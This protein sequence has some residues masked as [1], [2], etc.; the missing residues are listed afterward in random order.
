MSGRSSQ[1]N[2][3]AARGGE[4]LGLPDDQIVVNLQGDEPELDPNTVNT[5][6]ARLS[7]RSRGA[8]A[9][10]ARCLNCQRR[11]NQMS[12]KLFALMGRA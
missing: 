7:Q 8:V 3:A 4:R 12:S 9:S 2:V 10:T 6:V 1:R 11:A 5:A